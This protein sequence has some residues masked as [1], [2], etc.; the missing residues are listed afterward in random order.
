MGMTPGKRILVADDETDLLQ[1]IASAHR[2]L[3]AE[4]ICSGSGAELIKKIA[5]EGPFALVVADISMPWMS[6]LHAMQTARFAGLAT[7]IVVITALTDPEIDEQVR[8][9]GRDA[10][11]LR[12]P[13]N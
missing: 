3:G 12:K 4:V 1:R 13:F 6:G 9:L 2:D 5:D 11:L 10:L 8:A 7:P